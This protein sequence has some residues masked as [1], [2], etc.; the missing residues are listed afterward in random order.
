MYNTT[1]Q[2]LVQTLFRNGRASCFA[3]GQ[4]GSGKTHTM[5]PLPIRAAA[6]ILRY[7]SLEQYLDV[8]LWVSCFEIYGNKVRLGGTGR[9]GRCRAGWAGCRGE[10]PPPGGAVDAT[11]LLRR[12]NVRQA[13]ASALRPGCQR[14]GR[15]AASPER[16]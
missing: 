12:A 7:L 3:Y 4:T 11:A 2:P 5:S 15:A 16:T 14:R 8:T 9:D 13:V 1:V 6:D 10:G